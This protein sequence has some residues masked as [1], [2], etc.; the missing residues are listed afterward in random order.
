MGERM[1]GSMAVLL[2]ATSFAWGQGFTR[3]FPPAPAVAAGDPVGTA[4]PPAFPPSDGP[5]LGV[6]GDHALGTPSDWEGPG[7]FGPDGPSPDGQDPD[8]KKDR[9]PLMPPVPCGPD[10][11]V[12]GEFLYWWT[13]NAPVPVPLLTTG[14]VTNPVQAG[15]GILGNS[16]TQTLLGNESLDQGQSPGLRVTAGTWIGG[17]PRV[18]YQALGAEIS[19]FTLG[20]R[21]DHL[22]FASNGAGFPVL[23][24]PVYDI[25]AQQETVLLVS[26]PSPNGTQL[27]TPGSFR[28]TTSNELWGAEANVFKPICGKQC[29]LVGGILGFRYLNLEEGLTL[30]QTTKVL[31]NGSAFFLG[32]PVNAPAVLHL[33]DDFQTR[34]NFYGGQVGA[35]AVFRYGPFAL[36]TVGKIAIGSMH[37][38]I[39]ISG[40]TTVDQALLPPRTA[41]GGLLALGS[42]IGDYGHYVW[43]VVP[44]ANVNLSC[45]LLE[46]VAVTVGYTFLYASTVLRPGTQID[47]TIN[48]TE[49]PT[50]AS[51][52]PF[53]IG[54]PRPYFVFHNSDFW[55]QGVNVGLNISF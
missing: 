11:W 41:D 48:P 6:P 45:Q 3:P 52:S 29:L 8:K 15:Y 17:V 16:S 31:N 27:G 35:Q 22:D 20:R 26:S 40:S 42:N 36:T 44:E 13:K 7:A 28:V 49:L 12:D 2:A 23:A 54:Q 38:V 1:L 18:G 33:N 50:S 19:Y 4:D 46:H 30:D 9:W 25:L 37:E 55:A 5:P 51:F 34:N 14:P 39:H 10:V 24:R 32:Q 21:S 53:P 47:R 43:S